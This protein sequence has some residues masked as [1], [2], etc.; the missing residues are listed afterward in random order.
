[1]T[2]RVD[3]EDGELDEIVS[4]RGAHL[5]SLGND[6]WFLCFEHADGTSTALW[7]TSRDLVKP[8]WETRPAIDRARCV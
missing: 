7:F 8:M 1:M 4:T 2:D 5:E 3:F 6:Q